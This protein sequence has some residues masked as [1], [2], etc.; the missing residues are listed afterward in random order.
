[1]RPRA[2]SRDGT[3]SHRYRCLDIVAT[4]N[5]RHCRTL[6]IR[7]QDLEW[8]KRRGGGGSD[9]NR[10]GVAISSNQRCDV[11]RMSARRRATPF[12]APN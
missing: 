2:R 1:M 6:L 12:S 9:G 8:Q 4:R 10:G 3:F 11:D 7:S 5:A